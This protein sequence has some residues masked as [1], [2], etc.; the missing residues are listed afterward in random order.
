MRLLAFPL[1]VLVAGCQPPAP[2]VETPFEPPPQAAM[3]SPTPAS[4]PGWTFSPD[5]VVWLEV[6]GLTADPR[7]AGGRRT[8]HERDW[9]EPTGSVLVR[10]GDSWRL[11]DGDGDGE[12]DGPIGPGQVAWVTWQVDVPIAGV[13]ELLRAAASELPCAGLA[14]PQEPKK[15]GVIVRLG[16]E[17]SVVGLEMFPVAPGLWIVARPGADARWLATDRGFG[18][19][20]EHFNAA[21]S[22]PG[23]RE[24]ARHRQSCAIPVSPNARPT[25]VDVKLQ[26]AGLGPGSKTHL[27]LRG[28]GGRYA[29]EALQVRGRP[30]EDREWSGALPGTI[31]RPLVALLTDGVRCG[32]APRVMTRTDDF[33]R[34]SVHLRF[35]DPPWMVAVSSESQGVGGAPW[36]VSGR[37]GAAL[38]EGAR[39]DGAIF[40]ALRALIEAAEAT[41]PEYAPAPERRQGRR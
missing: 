27:A 5:D 2:R 3:P 12:S 15:G 31:A 28:E 14:P 30:V 1:L 22:A 36:R 7:A 10:A 18:P 29:F 40:D 6:V 13:L 11:G 19:A 8:V 39:D 34:R 26:W 16:F 25:A 32:D 4:C 38:L 35:A 20:L 41:A 17:E 33:P 24:W 21:V 9:N 37:S 23:R